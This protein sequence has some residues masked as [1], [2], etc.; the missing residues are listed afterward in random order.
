MNPKDSD[1]QWK[2]SGKKQL[3]SSN[4]VELHGINRIRTGEAQPENGIDN[5][6][7]K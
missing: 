4:S 2:R 7:T 1:D 5:K 3:D 6:M